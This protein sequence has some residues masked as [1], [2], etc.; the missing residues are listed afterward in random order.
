MNADFSLTPAG[1]RLCIKNFHLIGVVLLFEF[2]LRILTKI[3][4]VNGKPKYPLLSPIF[5]CAITPIFYLF[6]FIFRISMEEA[7]ANGYFFPSVDGVSNVTAEV[8]T[9]YTPNSIFASDI[10]DIW[11]V[12]NFSTISWSAVIKSIPTL[13]SLTTFSLIHVPI[14]IPAFSISSG[15]DCDMN[16]ELKAHGYSNALAGM[17]GGKILHLSVTLNI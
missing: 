4:T 10:F 15:V 17:F 11:T 13:V 9:N 6:L 7:Q 5:Y 14:N 16:V 8:G 12:I 1:I 3:T 2:T